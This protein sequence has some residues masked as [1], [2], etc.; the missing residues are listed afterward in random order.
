MEIIIYR[1]K[2]YNYRDFIAALEKMGHTLDIFFYDIKDFDDDPDFFF[3]MEKQLKQKKYD[4]MMSINYFTVISNVCEKNKLPYISWN[5]DSMLLSMYH[6]SIFNQ[7]NYIFTFDFA[8]VEK[9]KAMGV[10][11]IFYLPLAVDIERLE[12]VIRKEQK[13]K[14]QKEEKK[15]KNEKKQKKTKD[16]KG[17]KTGIS[18]VGNL[19]ER[20]RYDMIEPMLPDYLRGYLEASLW[21]QLHISGGNLLP[22][23]LTEEIL[24]Q[25]SEHFRLEK[26]KKS[27]ADLNLIFCSTV[28]GFK[29]ANLERELYLNALS[30]SYKTDLELY[31]NS[32]TKQL[33]F[34][35]NKGKLDY[36]E[37]MPIVFHNSR[38]NLNVTIPNIL[39]GIPLRVFDILGCRGF[40]LTTYR[41][42]L[43]RHFENG[44]DLVIF[45][46][47]ED[48][49]Q[50][51]QYFLEHEEERKRIAEHGY[52]KVKKH[53][54][55][56]V[57]L[58]QMF[59]ILEEHGIRETEQAI[60]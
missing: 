22:E 2:A 12:S 27:F 40:C 58:Q 25:L 55:Y 4:L 56:F 32:E 36:W 43:L 8:E 10:K 26:N 28:L 7:C 59:C 44:K 35:Q 20:N 21:A 57:R 31:T 34:V 49:L 42:D 33:P 48:L 3:Y 23:M 29:A 24:I 45:E 15:Q 17:Q 16:N 30:L 1:W 37:E 13:E 6:Q 47:K 38:I 14:K 41:K 18:F 46:G 60:F 53:H 5:C 11:H 19:Y 54:T 51:V 52:Q 50:K 9:F 39:D